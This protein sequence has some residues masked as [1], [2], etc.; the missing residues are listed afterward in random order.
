MEDKRRVDGLGENEVESRLR[1]RTRMNVYNIEEILEEGQRLF[2]AVQEA[3]DSSGRL[4]SENFMRL[5]SKRLYPDYY[6]LIEKPIAL[7]TIREKLRKKDYA[8]T[9]EIRDDFMQICSNARR[10]NVTESQIYQ[11]AQ[12]IGKII[13]TWA[14]EVNI[15][16]KVEE[17]KRFKIVHKNSQKNVSELSQEILSELKAMKDSSGR[18]YSD[19]FLEIPSK[20]EYPE[21]YQIIQKPMS[22]NI[23]EKKI[24]K[25]QYARLLDFENDIRLIFANAMVF[26]ED[27]SQISNDAKILLKFFQRKIAKKKESL[28]QFEEPESSPIKVKLNV[29]Q[30]STPKI[31]LSIGPKPSVTTDTSE[32]PKSIIRLPMSPQAKNSN[33]KTEETDSN[34]AKSKT[35]TPASIPASTTMSTRSIPLAPIPKLVAAPFSST[36]QTPIHL[37]KYSPHDIVAVSQSPLRPKQTSESSWKW[38][39]TKDGAQPLISLITLHTPSFLDIPSPYQ[40]HLPSSPY[41]SKISTII[42]PATHHTLLVTPTLSSSLLSKPYHFTVA[43]NSLK[44]APNISPNVFLSRRSDTHFPKNTYEVKL[45]KGVN[46]IECVLTVPSKSS[47]KNTPPIESSDKERLVI[48]VFLY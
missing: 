35:L 1:K 41:G 9:D 30:S 47:S 24:K 44:I 26:N 8:S 46:A 27:G 34:T 48:F 10:Y 13:K 21:Y 37:S 3:K 2:K 43:I 22:F 18:T 29:S 42:L 17:A 4:I 16:N 5:P 6:E 7:E 40:I 32:T 36:S 33:F 28:D 39:E 15:S 25:N 20:K 45:S 12:Q 23:I 14:E 38:S 19:I 11:D 31:R